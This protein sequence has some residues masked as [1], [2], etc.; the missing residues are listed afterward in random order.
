MIVSKNNSNYFNQQ[1]SIIIAEELSKTNNSNSNS[2]NHNKNNNDS[3][4]TDNN[5]GI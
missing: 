2:N 3:N 1:L 4:G 5:N